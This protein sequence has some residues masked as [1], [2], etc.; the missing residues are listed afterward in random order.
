MMYVVPTDSPIEIRE[1]KKVN[2]KGGT[3]IDGFPSVGLANAIASEC[4]VHSLTTELVAVL[5][6]PGF[7]SLSIIQNGTPN[8]PARI[9]ANEELKL[10][11]FVSE[12]NFD[13]SMYRPIAK[14][15]LRWAI[16][17][18]CELVIS[19][20]GLPDDE[21]QEE[22]DTKTTEPVVYATAST[23]KAVQKFTRAGIEQ[24]SS[25]SVTGIPAL[26]LNEGTWLKKDVIVLLVKVLK[27][28][29]DFRAAAVVSQSVSKL[30]PGASCDIMSLLKE[31]E[32]VEKKLRRIKI[33]QPKTN[34]GLYG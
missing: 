15:I 9:Y 19:A 28:A 24:L 30:V 18:E 32:L 23:K 13:Q 14:T 34:L 8:F 29:P 5:D 26:L 11:I 1:V 25:G 22:D 27:D 21:T 33:E 3:V 7:P 6:S 20:A 17:K 2:L 31:A 16:E 12:L 10:A 4:F